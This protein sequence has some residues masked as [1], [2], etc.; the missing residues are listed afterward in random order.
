MAFNPTL[1]VENTELDAAQMR[2]QFNGLKD[3]IDAQAGQ[4]AAQ[5]SQLD[6][7]AAQIAELHSLLFLS[8][9]AIDSDQHCNGF[10]R[11]SKSL[12]PHAPDAWEFIAGYEA[13]PD[14]NVDLTNS[15]SLGVL[16]G[17]DDDGTNWIKTGNNTTSNQ[18][19]A[20]RYRINGLWSPFSNWILSEL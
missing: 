12:L 5:Q 16:A 4:I 18:Y 2:S 19:M 3:F 20:V 9:P 14:P 17:S 8:A 7:Q 15:T 11:I 13:T 10:A 1:P 6:A